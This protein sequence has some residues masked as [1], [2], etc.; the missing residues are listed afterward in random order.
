M[1]VKT[2]ARVRSLLHDFSRGVTTPAAFRLIGRPQAPEIPESLH[3]LLSAKSWDFGILA[4]LSFEHATQRRWQ[5]VIHEDGT[6]TSEQR[7]AIMR[8]LPD[9]RFIAKPEADMRAEEYLAGHP[10]C[11]KQ[12]R[13]HPFMLK[14][15]DLPAF[16]PAERFVCLD[17]D[18]IFF[19]R[20]GEVIDW[21][22]SGRHECWFNK[23]TRE[24]YSSPRQEIEAALGIPLWDSVNSGL[25]LMTKRAISLDLSE[26]HLAA[27]EGRAQ[28][29]QFFEQT[30][31]AL[32]ASA[33]NQGGLL[34][35]TYEISWNL[36]RQPGCIC[37][38]YVGP[39]NKDLLYI[40]GAHS[41]LAAVALGKFRS[42]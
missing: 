38:H 33:Y 24:T 23:D 32:N 9:S 11:L 8:F 5:M 18:V 40:E 12:R 4:A 42:A 29:P 3:L 17:S 19:Q 21:V 36:W 26:Q 10:L 1:F 39:A 28:H 31:W 2:R 15:F 35:R 25:C 7:K 20:A 22:A 6:I 34:P 14:F 41:L 37:R 16:A 13:D 27:F 30:L